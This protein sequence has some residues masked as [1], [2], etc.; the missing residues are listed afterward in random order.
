MWTNL[1]VRESRLLVLPASL[2]IAPKTKFTF[3]L[4]LKNQSKFKAFHMKL[5]TDLDGNEP[6]DEHIFIKMVSH[7][8]SFWN[9][10][11]RELDVA[12]WFLYL[13]RLPKFYSIMINSG[14]TFYAFISLIIEE[15][16]YSVTAHLQR[17]PRCVF[18]CRGFWFQRYL[19]L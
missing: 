9:R 17:A 11:T 1:K 13:L 15:F 4:Y 10:G 2:K 5:R 16:E 12:Y 8:D 3:H 7:L 14:E 19:D 18:V 6:V